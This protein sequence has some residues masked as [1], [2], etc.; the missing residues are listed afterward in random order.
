MAEHEI[1]DNQPLRAVAHLPKFDGSNHREWNFEIDLVFQYHEL[2]DLVSGTELRPEEERNEA[3]ELQNDAAIRLWTR[4]NITALNFIFASIT[5]K[6]KENLYTPG[7]NAAQIWTKLN[8]QYQLQ[9]E[10]QLHL[11]WQQYYDFKHTAGTLT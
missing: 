9:T 1:Q 4:K 6:I 2:K 8:L 5:K 10:E 3:G 7:L 11:L